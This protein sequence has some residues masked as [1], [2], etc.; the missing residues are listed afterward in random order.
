MGAPSLSSLA[1]AISHPFTPNE[2]W[3]VA[4]YLGLAI[5]TGFSQLLWLSKDAFRYK[6]L[7]SWDITIAW[8]LNLIT[9]AI[10]VMTIQAAKKTRAVLIANSVVVYATPIIASILALILCYFPEVNGL[11][12]LFWLTSIL[13]AVF[14][15]ILWV[16]WAECHASARSRYSL[17]HVTVSFGA[18]FIAVVLL[19]LFLPDNI[20]PAFI[21]VLPT[22]S[23]ILLWST[24]KHVDKTF[25]PLLP[26][27]I[28]IAVRPNITVVCAVVFSMC[29]VCTFVGGMIPQSVS[30]ASFGLIVGTLSG[31]AMMLVLAL[32]H[33]ISKK[34]LTIFQL[35]P[36]VIIV[37]MSAFAL[38][39]YGPETYEE[40]CVIVLG[41]P[42]VFQVMLVVYFGKLA[43]KGY[44]APSLMFALSL[45]CSQ[46]GVAAEDVLSLIVETL[47]APALEST[48]T[49]ICSAFML[50]QA[51]LI[52]LLT[53]QEF[54][55]E[56]LMSDPVPRE[57][58]ELIC[59]EMAAEFKLSPR[60]TEILRLLAQG[61]STN[62]IAEKFFIS[63]N[64][65]NTHIRHIYEKTSIHSRAELIDYVN[66]RN[67]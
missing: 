28:S 54:L 20:V 16:L 65:V 12:W 15:V 29:T 52:I 66:M 32:I 33:F 2:R 25:P 35:A 55:L 18:V 57:K 31:G 43:T 42:L 14:E 1:A 56:R 58:A 7:M 53:R 61:A 3:H 62:K 24:L 6:D 30:T 26:R 13:L 48:A 63:P 39:L 67:D 21:S 10:A 60:E 22:L 41:C 11:T 27:S 5:L 8:L 9:L 47:P 44:F 34:K 40:A 17:G 45:L 19:S 4:K 49:I 36:W 37:A 64:T 50:F 51:A 59:E 46:I 23:G 38:Y